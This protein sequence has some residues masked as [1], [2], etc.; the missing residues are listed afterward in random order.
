[1]PGESSK[2]SKLSRK[3]IMA[4]LS[5][6]VTTSYATKSRG[7]GWYEEQEESSHPCYVAVG[8]FEERVHLPVGL[9]EGPQWELRHPVALIPP[10]NDQCQ[11][12][13]RRRIKGNPMLRRS[14]PIETLP[15][16]K[17]KNNYYKYHK[18]YRHITSECRELEKVLHELAIRDCSTT[19]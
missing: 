4:C 13:A 3:P 6:Y 2:L 8:G 14:K 16:F 19:S 1:M 12:R 7:A 17:N 5:R 18:D 9:W 10:P 15:K 11:E